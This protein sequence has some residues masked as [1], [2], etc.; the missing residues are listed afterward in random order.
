MAEKDKPERRED[1][2]LGNTSSR[3]VHPGR[4]P[5]H[6]HAMLS[7]R[8]KAANWTGEL[9]RDSGKSEF[10]EKF[11]LLHLV[12]CLFDIRESGP[13]VALGIQT[14]GSVVVLPGRNSN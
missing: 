14:I 10:V 7:G 9:G 1:K 12:E 13:H 5:V 8:Q 11:V 2:I 3:R 4:S 6:S